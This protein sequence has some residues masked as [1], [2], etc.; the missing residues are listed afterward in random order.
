VSAVGR[1]DH[2][3]NKA[4]REGLKPVVMSGFVAVRWMMLLQKS[5]V[6]PFASRETRFLDEPAK[7]LWFSGVDAGWMEQRGE[8]LLAYRYGQIQMVG[9]SHKV[10]VNF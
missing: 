3:S 10:P 7:H 6:S 8:S 5:S 4:S 2:Y 9:L 1:L